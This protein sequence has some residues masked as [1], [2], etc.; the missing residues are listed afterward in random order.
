LLDHLNNIH[1]ASLWAIPWLAFLTGLG[2]SLHCAGMCGGLTLAA[3]GEKKSGI[4]LYQIGRVFSYVLLGLLSGWIGSKIQLQLLPKNMF[5]FSSLFMSIF[6]I[7]WGV[8]V[9]RKKSLDIS[10]PA[11]AKNQ[12]NK[13][14]KFFFSLK[15]GSLKSAG[16]GSLSIFLPCGFL[17][18]AVFAVSLL[19]SPL[20]SALAMLAF[21][22]GTVPSLVL[23]PSLIRRFL[24]PL[25]QRVPRLTS[26]LLISF[27]VGTII[28]RMIN[29]YGQQGPSCH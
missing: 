18:G 15:N 4:F 29:F 1:Q 2:G 21:W 7:Y 14:W 26:I 25:A 6:F 20:L 22:L 8:I 10:L 3:S 5:I 13:S 9:W 24:N 28:I 11:F 12:M 27:G 17:Y 19:Q 23:A 16:L